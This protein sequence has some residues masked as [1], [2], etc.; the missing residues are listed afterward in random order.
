MHVGG[1]PAENAQSR[2]GVLDAQSQ[3][4]ICGQARY[5][6][7][8]SLNILPSA[9]PIM[10]RLKFIVTASICLIALVTSACRS[11]NATGVLV[12]GFADEKPIFRTKIVL[13]S[14]DEEYQLRYELHQGN[15]VC[16]LTGKLPR[17]E[18]PTFNNC[19]GQTGTGRISCNDGRAMNLQWTLTSCEGGMGWS[20]ETT[21]PSFFFGFEHDKERALDQLAQAM[22]E[23]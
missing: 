7:G 21:G 15:T 16:L 9:S 3:R 4:S 22:R 1:L 5:R 10:A 19:K 20:V 14:R 23:N 8:K 18:L 17:E 11:G 12:G 6:L 13:P 2:T